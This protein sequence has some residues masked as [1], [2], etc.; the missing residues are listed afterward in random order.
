VD[1][2]PG[3]DREQII[4]D[5]RSSRFRGRVYVDAMSER[6]DANGK[7]HGFHIVLLSSA[8]GGKSFGHKVG[9]PLTDDTQFTGIFPGTMVVLTAEPL[10]SSTGIAY[11]G[12]L[13]R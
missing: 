9:I 7:S 6:V 12:S 11:P 1:L 3:F 5:Q 4:V 8:D 13:C 2:G 10:L